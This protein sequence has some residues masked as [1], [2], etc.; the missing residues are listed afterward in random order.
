MT[1]TPFPTNSVGM[2]LPGYSGTEKPLN[3]STS[4][5]S[6]FFLGGRAKLPLA[7]PG[8]R[9]DLSRKHY[10]WKHP[11]ILGHRISKYFLSE[12][13]DQNSFGIFGCDLSL[14]NAKPLSRKDS[15]HGVGTFRGRGSGEQ[16]DAAV[17]PFQQQ[18]PPAVFWDRAGGILGCRG[19]AWSPGLGNFFL[20]GA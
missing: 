9:K 4:H 13:R 20:L 7:N 6:S 10:R 16:P 2:L 5:F 15:G 18:P 12:P 14:R 17:F 19:P 8:K 1:S 3:S 11:E